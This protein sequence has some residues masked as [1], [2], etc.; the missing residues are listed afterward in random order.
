M[1]S[2]SLTRVTLAPAKGAGAATTATCSCSLHHH[3]S[4]TFLAWP[5]LPH[6]SSP[7]LPWLPDLTDCL[8]RRTNNSCVFLLLL[9]LI[10]F[11][12]VF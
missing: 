6:L 2:P 7:P 3:Q 5:P 12:F 4:T 1:I 11:H 8:S 10:S 9:I